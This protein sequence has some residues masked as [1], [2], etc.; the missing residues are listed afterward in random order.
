MKGYQEADEWG[1]KTVDYEW[2]G[3]AF[4]VDAATGQFARTSSSA[5]PPHKENSAAKCVP[6]MSK[7]INI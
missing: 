5:Y 2:L 4:G 6:L 3:L 1:M 7:N